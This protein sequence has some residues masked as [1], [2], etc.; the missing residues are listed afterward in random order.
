MIGPTNIIQNITLS[1]DDSENLAESVLSN[2]TVAVE[3]LII[4]A[5]SES[6]EIKPSK[7]GKKTKLKDSVSDVAFN[8]ALKAFHKNLLKNVAKL[9]VKKL[10]SLDFYKIQEILRSDAKQDIKVQILQIELRKA[11][12]VEDEQS[13]N[14][15]TKM[16]LMS[17]A[18]YLK[19]AS[20]AFA[21]FAMS[22]FLSELI[23]RD[24]TIQ[25]VNNL[26]LLPE[27]MSSVMIDS[28]S[29][30][31]AL[32]AMQWKLDEHECTYSNS[33]NFPPNN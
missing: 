20:T 23:R 29:K 28:I 5:T 11:F 6:V 31:T 27:E 24:E 12:G 3:P 32:F 16:L 22:T 8:A 2:I 18:P 26:G 14:Q 10:S 17:S 4:E 33:R 9:T 25:M 13:I 1:V 19:K 30:S 7:G 21:K 15:M